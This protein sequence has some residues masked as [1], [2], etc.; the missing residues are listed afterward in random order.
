[1]SASTVIPVL[2]KYDIATFGYPDVIKSD[3]GTPCNSDAF[4]SSAK[5]VI[6][7]TSVQMGVTLT[8]K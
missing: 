8:E 1:M 5:R 4:A 2:G 7:W 6:F 3:N